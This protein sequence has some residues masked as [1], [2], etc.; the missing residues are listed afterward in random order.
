MASDISE[1]VH[2]EFQYCV[3][4]VIYPVDEKN[5]SYHLRPSREQAG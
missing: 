2:R 5:T 4:E 1:V 3:D